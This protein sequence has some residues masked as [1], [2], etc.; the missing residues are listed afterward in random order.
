MCL[1]KDVRLTAD[2]GV[3]SSIQ[4]RSHNYVEIDHDNFYGHSPPFHWNIQKGLLSVTRKKYVHELLV[5]RLFK[6]AKERVWLGELT[7][8]P[9]P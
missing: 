6:L 2:Q 5:Y 7:V 9:W 1:T 3:A 8:P 4:A